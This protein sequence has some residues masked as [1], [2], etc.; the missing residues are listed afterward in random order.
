MSIVDV[1][2]ILFSWKSF[3]ILIGLVAIVLGLGAADVIQRRRQAALERGALQ[4]IESLGGESV[5]TVACEPFWFQ[6]IPKRMRPQVP[7]RVSAVWIPAFGP[8]AT[9]E[10]DVVTQLKEFG[11]L[12]FVSLTMKNWQLALSP[13]PGHW[14]RFEYIKANLPNVKVAG[15]L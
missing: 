8:D 2:R 5:Q 3:L 15:L 7:R 11:C 9:Y 12:R 13:P 6:L 10:A 1:R 4:R 14:L